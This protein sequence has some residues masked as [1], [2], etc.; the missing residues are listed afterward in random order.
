MFEIPN[1]RFLKFLGLYIL[2]SWCLKTGIFTAQL[3]LRF[4]TVSA[5]SSIF[6]KAFSQTF[7]APK[8]LPKSFSKSS[9]Y[10]VTKIISLH[11]F[12]PK[13]VRSCLKQ[14]CHIGHLDVF[15]SAH[16][17]AL[18]AMRAREMLSLLF[19]SDKQLVRASL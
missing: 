8:L 14:N 2:T 10:F 15:R 13:F 5:A 4:D 1:F 12:L 11:T 18:H 7:D 17:P 19:R 3:L 16:A 9:Q 6:S